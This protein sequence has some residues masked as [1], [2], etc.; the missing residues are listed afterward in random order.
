M[1]KNHGSPTEEMLI[2]VKSFPRLA[3]FLTE[4][5]EKVD[6]LAS[7]LADISAKI[8]QLLD[9]SEDDPPAPE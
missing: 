3:R 5:E 9:Q 1:T 6:A 7:D 8:D 4:L 2:L